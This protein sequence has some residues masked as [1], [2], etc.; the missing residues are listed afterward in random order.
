M[1]AAATPDEPGEDS[2]T[3]GSR[4]L[5][6][7]AE[8]VQVLRG[9]TDEVFGALF[10]YSGEQL[11]TVSKDNTCNVWRAQRSSEGDGE[12][13]EQLREDDEIYDF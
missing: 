10:S 9:H 13:Q 2:G 6:C 1:Q 5:S 11:V 4:G 7:G 8:C 3:S 12:E